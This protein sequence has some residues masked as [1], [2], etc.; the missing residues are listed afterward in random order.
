MWE[1]C[2]HTDSV[3]LEYLAAVVRGIIAEN[4]VTK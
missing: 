4:E 3:L 2:L 1:K